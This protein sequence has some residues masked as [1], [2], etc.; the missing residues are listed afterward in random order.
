[1]IEQLQRYILSPAL[2]PVRLQAHSCMASF[3]RWLVCGRSLLHIRRLT[4]LGH[5]F[6]DTN[7]DYVMHQE[8]IHMLC[9]ADS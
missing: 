4:A 2:I 6:M 3:E 8:C 1:M 7:A 5:F 9:T